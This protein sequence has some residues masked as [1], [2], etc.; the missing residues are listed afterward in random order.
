MTRRFRYLLAAVA[1][2]AIVPSCAA[3]VL[4]LPPPAAP[5][6]VEGPDMDGYVTISGFVGPGNIAIAYN[7]N[8]MEGVFAFSDPA[9]GAYVLR[10]PA[11][12]GDIIELRQADSSFDRGSMVL[13]LPPIP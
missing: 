7:T 3:P 8:T 11:S 12:T 13:E 1:I 6:L 4:P 10:I 2:L 5:S 9:D